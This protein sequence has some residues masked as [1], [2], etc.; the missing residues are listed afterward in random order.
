M[1]NLWQQPSDLLM[2]K[3]GHGNL[4]CFCYNCQ[5][6]RQIIKRRTVKVNGLKW[7]SKESLS[8][9]YMLLQANPLIAVFR[10]IIWFCSKIV[11]LQLLASS[12]LVLLNRSYYA[13]IFSDT[14]LGL[15]PIKT[16]GTS[17]HMQQMLEEKPFTQQIVTMTSMAFI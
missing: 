14:F 9:L 15:K 10:E 17:Q 8:E 7:C 12:D 11:P 13:L 3:E 4:L 5:K 2:S 6:A 16:P 1:F